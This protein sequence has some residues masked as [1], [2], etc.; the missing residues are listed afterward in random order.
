M[1]LGVSPAQLVGKTVNGHKIVKP[2]GTSF[3]HRRWQVLRGLQSRTGCRQ[4]NSRSQISQNIR[5]ERTAVTREMS[6]GG[7]VTLSKVL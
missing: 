6:Q 1:S 4:P 3:S 2:I 7:V 5:H